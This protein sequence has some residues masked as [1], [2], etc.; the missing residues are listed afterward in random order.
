VIA[1]VPAV[2]GAALIFLVTQWLTGVTAAAALSGVM[3]FAI[4]CVETLVSV[5]WL[6]GR[7]ENFDL[8]E[9]LRV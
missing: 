5:R 7:F 4:L 8:S 6:G 3:A 2:I 9:E 1:T